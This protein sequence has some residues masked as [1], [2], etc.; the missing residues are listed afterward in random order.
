MPLM[1]Q[2]KSDRLLEKYLQKDD[3][4]QIKEYVDYANE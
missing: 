3:M 2:A 1:L 4:E